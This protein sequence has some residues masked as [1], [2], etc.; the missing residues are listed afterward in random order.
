MRWRLLIK[1]IFPGSCINPTVWRSKAVAGSEHALGEIDK[2]NVLC[3]N[4]RVCTYAESRC[5]KLELA[6]LT[7]LLWRRRTVIAL[8]LRDAR[9]SFNPSL[10]P[11]QRENLYSP[12]YLALVNES[13]CAPRLWRYLSVTECVSVAG[14]GKLRVLDGGR[15]AVNGRRDIWW[16]P[17]RHISLFSALLPFIY[18]P[19]VNL[20]CG[21]AARVV[22]TLSDRP[23]RRAF[24][25]NV[26]EPAPTRRDK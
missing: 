17:F 6:A 1:P 23:E 12:S 25:P 9:L 5:R 7:F 24:C 11:L 13:L 3:R 21:I 2:W 4:I 8:L 15:Y 10:S 16:R 26:A 18:F 20:S 19:L 14:R 22:A